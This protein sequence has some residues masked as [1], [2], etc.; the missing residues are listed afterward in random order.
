MDDEEGRVGEATRE[1]DMS[2]EKAIRT[3]D[4][5]T[6][7]STPATSTKGIGRGEK[8]TGTKKEEKDPGNKGIGPRPP[9][10]PLVEAPKRIPPRQIPAKNIN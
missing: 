3:D 8:T 10:K 1:T 4:P 9:I 5:V 7:L 6:S 2:T